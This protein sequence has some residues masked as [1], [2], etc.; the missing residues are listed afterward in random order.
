MY[1]IAIM[2]KANSGKNTLGK[3]IVR[4]IRREHNIYSPTKYLA[5]ADPIKEMI[6]QMF[7]SLPRKFLYGSSKYRNEIIPGAF[8]NGVPLTVRQ[9]LIDLGTGVGREYKPTVWLDNFDYRFSEAHCKIIVVPDVRFRNEFE[10]LRK[11]GFYLIRLYR[12]TGQPEIQH[13]SETGQE[14][15]RDEEF[16]YV[17]SNNSTLHNLRIEVSQQITPQLRDD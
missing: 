1:K 5:F 11:K 12:D 13:I 15:I 10:H 4:N 9:L 14:N 6:R 8:R 2:G 7:P 16:D 17:L 3:M